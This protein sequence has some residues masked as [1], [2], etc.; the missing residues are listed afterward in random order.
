MFGKPF[1]DIYTL[2]SKF[3]LIHGTRTAKAT[4]VAGNQGDGGVP[5]SK[6]FLFL[7]PKKGP[8]KPIGSR[9]LPRLR[10]GQARTVKLELRLPKGLTAGS[11]RLKALVKTGKGVTQYSRGNDAGL[12]AG[13]ILA[14]G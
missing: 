6:L 5:H 12:S 11:Y 2:V 9:E 1:A 13:T 8:P 4:V 7:V 3:K 10:S 14:G